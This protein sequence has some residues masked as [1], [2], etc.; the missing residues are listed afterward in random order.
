MTR[1]GTK[2]G[3]AMWSRSAGQGGQD[4]NNSDTDGGEVDVV[5]QGGSLS[6]FKH[7]GLMVFRLEKEFDWG[8]EG[9]RDRMF[10]CRRKRY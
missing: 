9:G 4:A 2:K 8:R 6:Q 7:H 5:G 10:R 1:V 3:I